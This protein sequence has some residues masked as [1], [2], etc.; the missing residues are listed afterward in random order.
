MKI[1]RGNT[2]KGIIF[3]NLATFFW[4][5]NIILG[6]YLR[7]S[8]GPVTLTAIRYCIA[9]LLFAA[10]YKNLPP[11]E[12]K[13]ERD[14]PL[15]AGM[16]LTGVILFAPVLYYA[17]RY[18]T[19]INGTLINGLG[20]LIAALFAAVFLKEPFSKGQTAGAVI[21]FAGVI[22]LISGGSLNFF[23]K[24]S[25]NTG[26]LLMILAVSIWALYSVISGRTV[27]K[28]SSLSAT[29]L[30]IFMALPVLIS[31]ALF[32]IRDIPLVFNPGMAALLIYIGIAPAALGFFFWNSGIQ[33][34]TAGG[35]MAFYNTLPLYGVIL[36][37]IFLG[38]EVTLPHIAGGILII[39]GGITAA[40]KKR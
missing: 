34:L 12:K 32:E 37:V 24:T 3:V 28:R 7:G 20:P 2:L 16:S 19:A 9:A 15:L 11:E 36:G 30:S 13:A 5:T 35:A 10:V 33:K 38:E 1:I 14:F 26:D 25:L 31:A 27:K 23:K 17:L 18:T 29:A 39:S 22:I 8:I 21:S 4:A 40:L 6:R